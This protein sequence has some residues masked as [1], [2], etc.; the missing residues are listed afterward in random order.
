[1]DSEVCASQRRTY[2]AELLSAESISP[3]AAKEILGALTALAAGDGGA[4]YELCWCGEIEAR[5]AGQGHILCCETTADI[6][7]WLSEKARLLESAG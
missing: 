4:G 6:V 2:L 7:R 5:T 1:M 3:E